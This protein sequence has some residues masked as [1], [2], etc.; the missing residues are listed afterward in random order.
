[1][2]IMRTR[3]Y[4]VMN[5][6]TLIASGLA[7]GFGMIAEQLTIGAVQSKSQ[8]ELD[9]DEG[10]TAPEDLMK[11]HGV[12]NR[13]LLLYE[14][15]LRRLQANQSVRPEVFS[16]TAKMIQQFVEEYHEKNEETYI[17][18][19]F[20]KANKL[21]D[22]VTTLKAQHLAGRKV[23]TAILNLSQPA[24]FRVASNRTQLAAECR[25]FIRMY[26]PH[27]SR[28]DTV[29]FPALRT[30]LTPAQVMDLG[31]RMEED[32]HRVLGD[33]GFEH[34]VDQV[35]ALERQLGIYDLTQFTPT[36]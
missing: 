25:S 7:T 14:E 11:E 8:V 5:R 24:A 13:C 2:T 16:Q 15:G 34:S 4:G 21:I 30:I 3:N 1:L 22:L 6:R 36:G 23:T 28:E 20:E 29:L 27:E 12:L 10:V 19:A 33:E 26:R 9:P 31:E 18:P 35:A 32:E 17:F